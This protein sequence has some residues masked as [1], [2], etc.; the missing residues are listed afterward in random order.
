MD[1]L[2]M[3]WEEEQPQFSAA[4]GR[5]I[6]PDRRWI[7]LDYSTLQITDMMSSIWGAPLAKVRAA[8]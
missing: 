8:R 3:L 7:R 2:Q 1:L 6:I 4:A 5:G